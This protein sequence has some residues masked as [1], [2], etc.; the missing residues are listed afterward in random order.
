MFCYL[1]SESKT[2][3]LDHDDFAELRGFL[4]SKH[5]EAKLHSALDRLQKE[6]FILEKTASQPAGFMTSGEVIVKSS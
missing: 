2:V 3:K 4:I 5:L 1:F 6:C